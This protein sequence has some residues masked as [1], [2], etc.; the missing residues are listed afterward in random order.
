MWPRRV[1]GCAGTFS[2]FLWLPSHHHILTSINRWFYPSSLHLVLGTMP[3]ETHRKLVTSS[4]D[5]GILVP[6]GCNATHLHISEHYR[7]DYT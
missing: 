2:K 3:W 6:G 1:H 7:C 5:S 4:R